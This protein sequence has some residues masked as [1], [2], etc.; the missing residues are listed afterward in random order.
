[1]KFLMIAAS[2]LALEAY[3]VSLL[4]SQEASDFGP[5]NGG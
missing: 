4:T 5:M 1:M 3:S 2:V